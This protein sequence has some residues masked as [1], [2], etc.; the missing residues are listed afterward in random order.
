MP[1]WEA[2]HHAAARIAADAGHAVLE[3]ARTSGLEPSVLREVADRESHE[4]ITAALA[5]AFPDDAVRSE[6]GIRDASAH[7]GTDRVWIVDPLD[8]TWEYG[9]GRDD[10]GV[11]VAFWSAGALRAGAV[12]LPARGEVHG[13][14]LPPR[15]LP[16]LPPRVRM[17][18]S[19][20]RAH[21]QALAV[22]HALGAEVV[23][24]GSAGAKVG[25][26]L[27]GMA[28]VYAHAGGQY[29]WDSAAPVA[30]AQAAGLHASR[31]DGTPLAYNRPDPWLPDLLV[32]RAELAEA[33][34]AAVLAA[35][36]GPPSASNGPGR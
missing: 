34:V 27:S 9:Q 14:G 29:E 32:C 28:E 12:A 20:T 17:V 36:G 4:R 11:H 8:G 6:E 26:L 16:P 7:P 31:L 21:P 35:A 33:A 10:W 15:P 30:A 23:P 3:L 22:G 5:E 2:E 18:V 24:M 13:T 25:A 1:A 19:R